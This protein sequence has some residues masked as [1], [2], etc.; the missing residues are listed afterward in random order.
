M[1]LKIAAKISPI[2]GIAVSAPNT[3][4]RTSQS[5][6]GKFSSC[7]YPFEPPKEAN[8]CHVPRMAFPSATYLRRGTNFRFK[9]AR[10]RGIVP[11]MVPLKAIHYYRTGDM[12]LHGE[13]TSSIKAAFSK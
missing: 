8:F 7:Y 10:R 5:A 1:T 11:F 3:L 9:L 2:T 13:R 12:S 6:I 4:S